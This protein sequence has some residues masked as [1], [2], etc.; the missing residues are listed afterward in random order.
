MTTIKEMTY[1]EYELDSEFLQLLKKD[2]QRLDDSKLPPVKN[3]SCFGNDLKKL[4]T[5]EKHPRG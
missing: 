3:M 1:V 2:C 5:L 4:I